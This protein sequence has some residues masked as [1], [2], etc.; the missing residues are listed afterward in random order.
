MAKVETF[1]IHGRKA[2]QEFIAF[3]YTLYRDDPYWVPPLWTAQQQLLET[4]Q[5][6]FC[7]HAEIQGFLARRGQHTVGRVAAIIDRN[8]NEVHHEQAGF[9]GFFEAVNDP[10]V[11]GCL[12]DAAW[13][14]LRER[15][16]HFMRGPMNPSANYECGLLVEGFDSSPQ[17]LMC[18]NPRYYSALME[19]AGLRGVKD[20]YSYYLS[21]DMLTLDRVERVARRA[22]EA[23]QIHIRP[24][25]M[26]DFESEVERVWEVYNSAWSRNWGFVPMTR[27][28]CFYLAHELKPLAEPDLVLLAE[29]SG[30]LVGFLLALPDINQALK[31]TR[32]RFLPL[33][34]LTVLY[35]RRKIRSI[36]VVLL[37]VQEEF[38][39]AGVAAAL[40]TEII[41]RGLRLGYQEC[42]MSWILDDN[43]LMIRSVELLGGKRHKTYRLYERR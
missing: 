9:F 6:P 16:A 43:L 36:R 35:H 34:V 17:I 2:V 42:E 5:H 28:E 13:D 21:R 14:W 29:V 15:G 40:Y 30:R 38:R 18:Y 11:A 19:G 1:A 12:L 37:G 26:K 23:S 7:A 33:V 27:E 31:H 22:L 25:R 24:I 41:R 8:F 20:L 3:P 39:T 10:E 32:S 4:H